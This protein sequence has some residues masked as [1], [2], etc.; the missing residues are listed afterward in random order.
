MLQHLLGMEVGDEEGDVITLAVLACRK[1]LSPLPPHTLTGFLRRM[2]KASALC[3]RKRVNLCTR[4][5][6]ISSACLIFILIRTLLM[7]GSI[8]TL[9]FSFLD[10]VRG[11]SSTS[12]EL[13][14]SI[15]GTLCLSEACDAKLARERAAVSDERTHWR[16]GRRDWD[17]RRQQAA[18]SLPLLVRKYHP[19]VRSSPASSN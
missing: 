7:L 8:R 11:F 16:Y 18:L 12:G 13:A 4:M 5:C 9:S 3:V 10:T 19:V 1:L 15:S 6:S 17:C 2:K 14:A